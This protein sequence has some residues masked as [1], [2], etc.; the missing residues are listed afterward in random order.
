MRC[1]QGDRRSAAAP[2]HRAM[3]PRAPVRPLVLAGEHGQVL[4][5]SRTADVESGNGQSGSVGDRRHETGQTTS[6]SNERSTASGGDRGIAHPGVGRSWLCDL[7]PPHGTGQR[8]VGVTPS[9]ARGLG[10]TP[11]SAKGWVLPML[12]REGEL[13]VAP[14][15]RNRAFLSGRLCPA[16]KTAPE[17]AD[18]G[19]PPARP[20]GQRER[21]RS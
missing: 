8:C 1:Q 5:S 9:D 18:A 20:P 13:R 11:S 19:T 12:A 21:S 10:R 6:P 16:R 2:G 7:S 17:G 4:R 14:V 3:N 15:P